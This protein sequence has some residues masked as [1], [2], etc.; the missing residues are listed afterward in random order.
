MSAVLETPI[1]YEKRMED[2][3]LGW[4]L[5]AVAAMGA[6]HA[7]H[8][9][10][11]FT[12]F[13]LA[14]AVWRIGI[15]WRGWKRPSGKALKFLLLVSITTVL[16]TFRTLNG[17]EAGGAMLLLLAMLKLMESSTLRDYFLVMLV[18]YFL[19]IANFLYDQ[20]VPL[21]LYMIPAVWL[22]CMAQLNVAHPD[23]ERSFRE[24]ARSTGRLLLPALP[25]ALVLFLLFPRVSGP[26]WGFASM[27]HEGVT[28]L[29]STMS[30]GDLSELAQSDDVAFRVKFDG[31]APP[32]SQ[33][34]WRAL[35]LHDYDG[36]TWSSGNLPWQHK[37]QVATEGPALHYAVTLEPNNLQVLYALDLPVKVPDDAAL[38]ASYELLTRTAVT[39]RKL[40]DATSSTRYSYGA[41]MPG[42]ML[43]RDLNLP[44]GDD[45][46]ARAMAE[47]WRNTNTD[48]AKV[49]QAALDMFHQQNF[50]YTLQP[51]R[52]SG[53]NRVDQFLFGSRHGFCEH[54]AGAFVF[55]MRAAGIPAHVVIG[56]QGGAQ[57][58]LDGYYIVRQREAHAWA[59]IWLPG[60][61]WVRVDPTAA[62]DP[63]RVEQGVDAGL[64]EDEVAGSIFEEHPWLGDL[65]NGWDA[66]DNGWNQ[67]VLA[68]GPELQEKFYNSVGLEYGNWLELTLV[69]L[70]LFTLVFGAYWFYLRWERRPPPLS[71]VAKDY[72]RF[73]A[74]LARLGLVRARHEGP[75]DFGR[76]VVSARPD[77]ER[78]VL[79]ITDCYVEL[80]YEE[81]GDP[82][83]LRR[84]VRDFRPRKAA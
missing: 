73:C 67:W 28:G 21:A 23:P 66:V 19:G 15:A 31:A 2:Q 44:K 37:L 59:E 45:P 1:G 10:L 53:E 74:K 14:V 6:P 79:T 12:V 13:A 84:L 32:P 68:Y 46:K 61:G 34:Y 64:P 20:N 17:A 47:Q 29:S 33:L 54:Y 57:N 24:S 58:P 82:K 52:I 78:D 5:T 76:R 51:G 41:D 69:L 83:R 50:F 56:Y 42:W 62:V 27:K 9:P 49:A 55:L 25:V 18:A 8:L 48:P 11:W 4:A 65:R 63:A 71:P 75:L 16:L 3:R 80:R 40:Y 39:E 60:R 70:G 81:A 35:V 7:L 30:P 43:R 72:A 22:V 38:S 77:L 36:R 26:L